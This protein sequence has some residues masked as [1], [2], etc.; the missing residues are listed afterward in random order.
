MPLCV[1]GQ[2]LALVLLLFHN[3]NI[4]S[5]LRDKE[6]TSAKSEEDGTNDCEM[7]VLKDRKR[8]MDLYSLLGV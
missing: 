2:G 5:I 3:Y 1:Q 6:S 7:D 8:S 4:I